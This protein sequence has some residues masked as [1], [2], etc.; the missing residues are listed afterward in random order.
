M[1]PSA[2]LSPQPK[3]HLD[4]FS[5]FCTD[6]RRVS[7]YF[8]MGCPF[9]ISPSHW[10]SEPLSNT[11]FLGPTQV[12]NPNGISIGSAVFAGLTSV[13]DGQTTVLSCDNKPHLCTLSI[14]MQANNKRIKTVILTCP[15]LFP[16]VLC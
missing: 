3:R 4:R 6:D 8:T 11:W 7:P 15:H 12:L 1:I 13:T 5:C 9:K 10:G 14:V 2:H 16:K